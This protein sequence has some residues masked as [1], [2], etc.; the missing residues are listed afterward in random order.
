MWLDL[1]TEM[2]LMEDCRGERDVKSQK[3]VPMV[4]WRLEANTRTTL[5][6]R[7]IACRRVR[8]KAVLRGRQGW[9]VVD[10]LKL[11]KMFELGCSRWQ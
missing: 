8:V 11:V 4:G 2:G 1:G 7:A 9:S 6:S 3:I 5:Q 10:E